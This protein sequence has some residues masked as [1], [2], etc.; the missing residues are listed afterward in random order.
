MGKPAKKAPDDTGRCQAVPEWPQLHGPDPWTFAAFAALWP[1]LGQ[2]LLE[3][4]CLFLRQRT[5]AVW[6]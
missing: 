3:A 6:A 5:I 1:Q 2:A 4:G